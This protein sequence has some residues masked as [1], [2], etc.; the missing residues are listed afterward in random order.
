M[1]PIVCAAT[2]GCAQR[3]GGEN[4]LVSATEMLQKAKSRSLCS[5]TVQHQQLEWTKAIRCSEEEC[6]S[7]VIL[8]VSEGAGKIYDRIQ[9]CS[10][11]G[12]G[13]VRRDEH[14]SSVYNTWIT[15]ATKDV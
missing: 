4:M 8:G 10:R 9:D 12:R 7:P 6:K 15:A 11:Y 5:R 3:I 13:N 14:H 2:D 1:K